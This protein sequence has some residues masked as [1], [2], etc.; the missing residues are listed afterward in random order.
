[1]RQ[2]LYWALGLLISQA[3]GLA[4]A[5]ELGQGFG[6][7]A[8]GTPL[9]ALE[10][11]DQISRDGNL[12]YHRRPD[13]VYHMPNV[14]SGPVRYGFFEERFFAAYL[15]LDGREAFEQARRSLTGRY[16]EA[17]AQLRLGSTILIW[18]SGEVTIKLKHYEKEGRAK[19]AYYYAPLSERLNRE[20]LDQD[21][22]KS[23]KLAPAE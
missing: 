20:R 2:I 21:F 8:W 4:G 18:Q 12:S 23:F 10:G 22:E 15:N 9:S 7:I 1:M 16:G 3:M 17:R 13:E 11:F 19:L 5:A 6:G 14:Y